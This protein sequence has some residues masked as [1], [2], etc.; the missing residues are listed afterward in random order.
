MPSYAYNY[1]TTAGNLYNQGIQNLVDFGNRYPENETVG[2]MVAGHLADSFATQA[3]T[4]S[5]LA[6]NNAFLGSLA[7]Y[8]GG[9]ENLRTGNQMRLM[10]AE[11]SIAG[12]L[13]DKQG[14][15]QTRA[16]DTQGAW[17]MRGLQETGLQQRQNIGAQGTQDR[18][19]IATTGIE[20][21]LGM[22]ETGSQQRQNIGAQGTQ[23]RMNIAATGTEQR[24]GMKT[25]GAEDRLTVGEAGRQERLNIGERTT[26]DLR[27]RADA[28]GSVRREGARF[29]G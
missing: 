2:G 18:M 15:W 21:R 3:N 29:F 4:G 16:L 22:R 26:Q 11:G 9:M 13:I 27:A 20:Q 6:Y 24:L 5:A 28:R 12:G 1:G 14:G 10:A 7:N 19:N 8:Q 17:Q 23:D 25:K